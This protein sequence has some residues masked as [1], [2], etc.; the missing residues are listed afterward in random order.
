MVIKVE[1]LN[2]KARYD[3]DIEEVKENPEKW[4]KIRKLKIFICDLLQFSIDK[5]KLTKY[6]I[7]R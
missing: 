2:R 1:I 3:Y 5:L 6:N 4:T 7:D